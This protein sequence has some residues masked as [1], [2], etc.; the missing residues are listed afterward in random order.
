MITMDTNHGH[1]N[2]RVADPNEPSTWSAPPSWMLVP[3]TPPD[4]LP[5]VDTRH[6]LLPL[7][8][9]AW[10]NF[11]RLCLRLLALDVET[12]HV[13][14]MS[15]SMETTTPATGMYGRRGQAQAGIDVYARDGLI[16]GD[17]PPARRYVSLQARRIQSVTEGTLRASV[18]EFLN[19]RWAEVSRKFVYATSVALISTELAHEIDR[20]A[21]RL[22]ERSI[23][24]EVWDQEAI[25]TRLKARP[26]LVDDFF[27]RQWTESFCGGPAAES[28]GSH[29]DAHQVTALRRELARIYAASFGI[30]DSGLIALRLSE[31]SPA[32][33]QERFV[34]PDVVSTTPQAASIAYPVEIASEVSADDQDMRAVVEE[35]GSWPSLISDEG[36][37]L[38]RRSAHRRARGEN[39]QVP[40]RQSADQWLGTARLQVIV[41]DPG[42]GKSTL[43]RYMVLDLLSDEPKLSRVAERWGQCLPVWLP[44]HFFTQRVAGQTGALASVGEALKAWLEQHDAGQVWPLVQAALEDRRL[45]LVVDGLDEWVNEEAGKYAI[46]ALQAFANSRSTP[47]IASTRPFGLARLTLAGDWTYMRIAPLTPDQQRQLAFH[48]F[49]AVVD[50]RERPASL[51]VIERSVD[52]FL[53]QVN[54]ARDLRGISRTPLFLVLLVGLHLSNVTTLPAGR[55]DVYNQIVQL[56]VA[57]HPAKRRVAAAVTAPRQRLSDR[58]IRTL[59]ARV[60]FSSQMRGDISTS[61]EVVLREDLLEALRDPTYL[62]MSTTDAMDTT[63]RLLTIAEGELGL[64]VRKGPGELGFLHRMLQ[65]QLAAEHVSDRL[66]TTELNQLF[67]EHLGDPRWREILLAT[68]WRISRPS[69]L[70]ELIEV[71][72][73]AINETASGLRAREILAEVTFGAYGLPAS[74]IQRIAPSIIDVIETHSYGPHRARLLESVLPGLEE[75]ATVDIV[76]E[77]LE[78]WTLL[79][80]EPSVG[81]VEQIAHLSPANDRS[82]TICTLLVSA[83]RHPDRW[84][85]FAAAQA[86]ATRCSDVGIADDDERLLLRNELFNLLADPPSGLAQAAALTGLALAWQNDPDVVDLLDEARA[87]TDN[88]VRIVA[89]SNVLG[90]FQTAFPNVSVRSSNYAQALNESESEFLMGHLWKH[91]RT[92][93]PSELLVAA[94]SE[95]LPSRH[96]DVTQL[97]NGLMERSWAGINSELGW[98]VALRVLADDDRFVQIVC[99]QLQSEKGSVLISRMTIHQGLL[100]DAY[101]PTSPNRDRLANAIEARLESFEPSWLSYETLEY[102]AID[103]GPLMKDA[104]LHDLTTSSFPHWSAEALTRYFSDDTEVRVMLQSMLM[105]EAHVASMI[106]NVAT[107]V[108]A[109]DVVVPRLLQIMRDLSKATEPEQGRYDIVAAALVRAYRENL[110]EPGLKCEAI[111]TEALN[112]LPPVGDPLLG[113]ARYSLAAAFY[114]LSTSA[115]ILDELEN[116]DDRPLELYL[117]VF[118]DDP[119]RIESLLPQASNMLRSLPAYLRAQTCQFLAERANAPDIVLGLTRK[120]TDE[121]SSLNKSVASLAYHRALLK[122][123]EAGQLTNTQWNL[124]LEHLGSQASSYGF[125]HESKRR[126]AWVGMCVCNNWSPVKDQTETRGE[127]SAVAVTLTDVLRGPDW[128]LLEE[129]ASNWDKLRSEFGDTLFSR[130]AGRRFNQTEN[131]VWNTLALIAPRN[132]KIQQ[133][134]EAAISNDPSLIKSDNILVWY[135]T[136]RNTN[137]EALISALALHLRTSVD[138]TDT[139][140][141]ILLSESSR[142]QLYGEELR[143]LLESEL[144]SFTPYSND[145]A[146][147][148]LAVL[149]PEH[150]AVSK[151]WQELQ[152]LIDE[153]RAGAEHPIHTQT[154]FAIAYASADASEIPHQMARHCERL[155]EVDHS[156]YDAVFVRHTSH[157]LR[158][159][160]RA[161]QMVRD[162]IMNPEMPD[163]RAAPLVSLL[164]DAVGLDQGVLQE[165]DRRLANQNGVRLAPVIRDHGVSANYSVRTILTR[166]TD[167]AWYSGVS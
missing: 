53:A 134:L 159:D 96:A 126:A 4:V 104:L 52:S 1:P 166:V 88:N 35:T 26:E 2:P 145:P 150:P 129:L 165:V 69:E 149:F 48:Y 128:I 64:L 125:D 51:E 30:A 13:S 130:L 98:L 29:L 148:A 120:W 144:R 107:R 65:E 56:L 43:L 157:R 44:F 153:V 116:A 112:N 28:L 33:L 50:T 40:E 117:Q 67:T 114:P 38:L 163:H 37:R 97:L 147:Q 154:Y 123:R 106:S 80:R 27:G 73:K 3:S 41:G 140:V 32:G 99:D 42:A 74:D 45:L 111:I 58:Q 71:I 108:L 78:R 90:V 59:L 95:L 118:R 105:G 17:S 22:L 93:V 109:S 77:C 82:H 132:S 14:T 141:N 131:E 49:R 89:L 127:P 61:R 101:P 46:A 54:D 39:P 24:F 137:N 34:T 122:L 158:R 121:V 160:A 21:S 62:A 139:L 19:G 161:V 110:I 136:K 20:L 55:F 143:I 12:V 135:V 156:Y 102:A 81:L 92:E 85:P 100:A 167:A 9:L 63:D 7:S 66:N 15:R 133:E 142:L 36:S 164:G 5:P 68:M 115:N 124:A 91:D 138:D 84:I 103:H 10:E 57:D 18:E 70:S 119:H 8:G 6:Q 113:D 72:Q 151:A 162:A 16:L 75:A 76:R 23:E 11:E 31:T 60:A 152:R 83:L 79:V 146:L 155:A 86:I 47:L 87:H 94:I 25:S